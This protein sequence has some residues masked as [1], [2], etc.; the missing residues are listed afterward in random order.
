M[1]ETTTSDPERTALTRPIRRLSD[2][3]ATILISVGGTGVILVVTAIF[4]F[5]AYET[6]PLWIP[7]SIDQTSSVMSSDSLET[8]QVVGVDEY[9]S[10]AYGITSRG[11]LVAY[12]LSNRRTLAVETPESSD[13]LSA[14]YS[15]VQEGTVTWATRLGRIRVSKI[16][17]IRNPAYPDSIRNVSFEQVGAFQS[18]RSIVARK[19]IGRELRDGGIGV[20]VVGEGGEV[21]YFLYRKTE[22]RISGETAEERSEIQLSVPSDENILSVALDHLGSKVVGGTDR[23]AL[24]VWDVRDPDVSRF[25]ERVTVAEGDAISA[26]EFLLGDQSVLVGSA[27]GAVRSLT[28]VADTLSSIGRKLVPL[29]TFNSHS[30]G[31]E[32]IAISSRNKSFLTLATDGEALLHYQTTGKTLLKIETPAH[33][34]YTAFSPKGD[35]VITLSRDGGLTAFRMNNPH[36]EVSMHILFGKVQYEGYAEPSYTWQSS[37]G[38]DDFEPKF[39]LVPLLFGTMKGA[40]Y[41]LIFALPLALFA[42]IYT[43][44]FAHQKI[45]NIVKPTVEIMAAL[46]S[47]VIGFIAALWFAPVLEQSFVAITTMAV[48]VPFSVL[49]GMSL[50]K[51]LPSKLVHRLPAGSELLAIFPS[52]VLIGYAGYLLG[53]WIEQE[54]FAGSYRHWLH[55]T[56]GVTYDQRNSIVVGFA[57]GFAVIPIIFTIS[58]DA[59]ASVPQHLT[60]GSLALGATRWQ[61]A[62]RVILPTASPGIFS[63]A[64]IGFGRAVGETMIVLMATGNTP[65]MDLGPFVGMRT[66]SA[67]IA[68]EIPEAPHLGTLYRVLFVSGLLLFLF[69]FVVN[70]IAELIRQRLRQRYSTI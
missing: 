69:T 49:L 11:A 13:T 5:I 45:K 6:L 59:L 27:K 64:M 63:A 53:P 35:G 33:L 60:A 36:P 57:M 2:R 3:L 40:F 37:G 26:V 65:L 39:S 4:V 66:L 24:L 1:N 70:T 56:L 25:V 17:V 28:W 42:A 67:N 41:A 8:L 48:L 54:L 31:I 46:P 21:Y 62:M 51:L 38:T 15:D 44:L 16:Q 22:N 50:W 52:L 19:V 12:D 29:N 32:S 68:V 47:V 61:T 55:D 18:P 9:Q 7:P 20:A 14:S 34:Q 10:V 30:S 58:E 43:A 23:G